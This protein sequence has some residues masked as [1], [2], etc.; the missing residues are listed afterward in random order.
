MRIPIAAAVE[1]VKK[2]HQTRRPRRPQ[3][4]ILGILGGLCALCVITS[5]FFTGSVAVLGLVVTGHA[6][7]SEVH[8]IAR[9]GDTP[10]ANVVV[11][12]DG[13]NV[14][15]EK[16]AQPVLDQR[17]LGF[18]PR[19]LAVRVGTV[20]EFP[21]HDRVFHN[22]FSFHDGKQFD[23]GLYPTGTVKHILFDKPG[24]SQLLCNIHPHMAAYIMAVDSPYFAVSDKDGAFTIRGL[25]PGTYTYHT[26]RPGGTETTGTATI[27]PATRLEI[28]CR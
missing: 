2:S 27:A 28:P 3:R 22:V 10:T 20:V 13:P 1:R 16:A 23:L 11:W 6:T 26:W 5:Y 8:G 24:L 4:K 18:S 25:A 19:V 12:I 14:P 15:M 9:V 7:S 17:N 21:N